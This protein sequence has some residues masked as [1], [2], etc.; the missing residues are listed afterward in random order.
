MI[1]AHSGLYTGVI[2]R[3]LQIIPSITIVLEEIQR[4]MGVDSPKSFE[5]D[6]WGNLY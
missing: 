1:A 5:I 6:L 4:T 3:R 2:Q